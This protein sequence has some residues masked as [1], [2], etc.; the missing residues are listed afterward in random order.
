MLI[1]Y[2]EWNPSGDSQAIV[3]KA[4]EILE[5]YTEQGYDLSLRQLYYQFVARDL[6]PNT[7][8]SYKKLGDIISKARDAGMIDWD[9]IKDRGRSLYGHTHYDSGEDF[10]EQMADRLHCNWWEGQ[11]RHVQVWVEKEAL[12]NVISRAASAWDVDYFP[13]KGY[14]SSS[15]IWEMGRRMLLSGCDNWIVI[16]L[17]DHDPS[18][19]DMTRDIS[20]RLALY[21]CPMRG[22]NPFHYDEPE[23]EVRRIAL[24]MDQID[25]YNP[26]P[27]PAKITD[28]R[29]RKYIAEYGDES[30]ELDA[31]EPSVIVKLIETHIQSAI[32]DFDL[33]EKRKEYQNEIRQKLREVQFN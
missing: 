20:D 3:T 5:E 6:I 1:K 2:K 10:L 4:N 8:K 16:H 29:A 9:L 23:I 30:W 17:G 33:F 18:G 13:C 28:T 11:D 12:A 26:P 14:M 32:N 31:L 27:N 15:S 24:N 22:E 19:I 21:S 7:E 25:E